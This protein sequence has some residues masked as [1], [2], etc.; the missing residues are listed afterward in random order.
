MK[1]TYTDARDGM[2][3]IGLSDDKGDH[4]F[5]LNTMDAADLIGALRASLEEA[6]GHPSADSMALPGMVRVQ[7]VE[8]AEELIFRVYMNDHVSHD[9]P[10]PKGTNI[11]TELKLLSDRMEARNQAKVTNQ[12]PDIPEGKP[13]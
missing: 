3:I 12:Q 13:N 11:A 10:V 7:M 2:V 5:S 4:E 1:L 9:Y 8:T 6:I